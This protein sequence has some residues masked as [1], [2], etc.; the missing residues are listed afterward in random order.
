M[1]EAKKALRVRGRGGRLCCRSRYFVSRFFI[2]LSHSFLV[3][4]HVII[5]SRTLQHDTRD[6]ES[7]QNGK[8][9][10]DII[11]TRIRT[12]HPALQHSPR[13]SHAADAEQGVLLQGL[14]GRLDLVSLQQQQVDVDLD[15]LD[16]LGNTIAN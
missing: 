12:D 15:R 14:Q 3:L 13:L 16:C 10:Y 5:F 11:T 7:A 4:L 2:F 8:T 6:K 9:L 1:Q